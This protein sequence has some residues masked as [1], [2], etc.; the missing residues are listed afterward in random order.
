[1]AFHLPFFA[2]R[3]APLPSMSDPKVRGKRLRS[4]KDLS[5]LKGESSNDKDQ[6]D[7]R[8]YTAQ[9]SCA[10]YGSDEWQYTVC[11]FVD[12]EHDSNEGSEL[13]DWH[14]DENDDAQELDQDPI[15]SSPSATMQASFPIWRPRQ[16][17]AKGLETAVEEVS[18]EWDQVVYMLEVDK[19]AYVCTQL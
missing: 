3:K 9:I 1:M 19:K 2:L 16:Y 4:W 6:E 12:T 5:L 18:Q 17:F 15:L 7:Y 8:L 13:Y 14:G 10:V 11:E